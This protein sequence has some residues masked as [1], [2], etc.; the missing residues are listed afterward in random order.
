VTYLQNRSPTQALKIKTPEE[1]FTGIRPQLGH[2]RVIGCVAYCHILAVKCTKLAP[3][4]LVTILLG[5]DSTSHAYRCWDPVSRKIIISRDI[6]F[7]KSSF[8]TKLLPLTEVL[9]NDLSVPPSS[10]ISAPIVALASFPV[11][12]SLTIH[13]PPSS[14]PAI[15][16]PSSPISSSPEALPLPVLPA[17]PVPG[18]LQE[19]PI[20]L[21]RHT[22]Y[23]Q[24]ILY[25]KF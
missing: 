18:Y 5:Y 7:D 2:L 21:L 8:D 1:A 22:L 15:S 20:L 4:A 14:L 3:K 6:Q 16:P 9:T 25:H 12:D 24:C 17:P 19:T 11:S 23:V 13:S 10:S